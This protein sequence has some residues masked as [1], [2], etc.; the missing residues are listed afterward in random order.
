[1]TVPFCCLEVVNRRPVLTSLAQWEADT[2]LQGTAAMVTEVHLWNYKQT[3]AA[4][5]NIFGIKNGDRTLLCWYFKSKSKSKSNDLCFLLSKFNNHFET[6]NLS[7]HGL[8]DY[9]GQIVFF[10]RWCFYIEEWKQSDWLKNSYTYTEFEVLEM[11]VGSNKKASN[12]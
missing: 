11:I 8:F 10:I 4:S 12:N 9:L 3:N 1:M 7:L 6:V 5:L 2:L